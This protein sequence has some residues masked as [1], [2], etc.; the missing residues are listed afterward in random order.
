MEFSHVCV[1]YDKKMTR[2]CYSMMTINTTF[3]FLPRR[4]NTTTHPCD[5]PCIVNVYNKPMQYTH[6][7]NPRL[8]SQG[9]FYYPCSFLQNNVVNFRSC[10]A[11]FKRKRHIKGT[12]QRA[13]RMSTVLKQLRLSAPFPDQI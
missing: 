5:K 2:Q 3:S 13:E 9:V 6:V 8:T 11:L 1:L 10:Q 12:L 7:I 4:F